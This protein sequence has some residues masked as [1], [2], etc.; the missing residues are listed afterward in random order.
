MSKEL[1]IAEFIHDKDHPT[2]PS[3]VDLWLENKADYKSC[4]IRIFEE[5]ELPR[6][7][8]LDMIILHGG[9]QHLWNKDAD[10]WLY[11]EIKY[12]QEALKKNI[13]VIG[14]CLGSQI[15]AEA[16]GAEVHKAE[17]KE[18]GF[19]RILTRQ[20]NLDQ[21][22]IKDI[23]YG[24]A[25]FEWHTDH[26]TLP[27]NCT[28]LAYTIAAENQ[29]FISDY[30][31]AV[32]FQF[33]PEYTKSIIKKYILNYPDENW[34]INNESQDFEKF[35]EYLDSMPDSLGLFNILIE[36]SLGWISKRLKRPL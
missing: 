13:P 7:D 34:K 11:K 30:F 26:H 28:S 10:P 36:N 32:G 14:F 5:L 31:P 27:E 21:M 2:E 17:V 19:Y 25:A 1:R 29:I 3:N 20:R 9:E 23:E 8:S 22:L 6:Y 24:F 4:K 12:I 35:I 33:H 15:I 18:A 16:L